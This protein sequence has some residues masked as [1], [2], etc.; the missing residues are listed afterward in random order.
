MRA[1][2]DERTAEL[3]ATLAARDEQLAAKDTRTAELEQLDAELSKQLAAA[4]ARP[5]IA[6]G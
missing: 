1:W 3:E 2:C 6:T 5:R 4:V